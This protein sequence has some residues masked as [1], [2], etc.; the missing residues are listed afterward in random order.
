MNGKIRR[1]YCAVCGGVTYGRQFHNQD[2]GYG[3]C[4]DSTEWLKSRMTQ[5]EMERIYGIEKLHFNLDACSD[6]GESGPCAPSCH[7]NT[8]YETLTNHR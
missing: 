6:C 2:T 5:D 3:L 8:D 7:T 1:L 4:A